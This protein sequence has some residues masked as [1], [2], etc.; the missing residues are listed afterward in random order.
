MNLK[1]HQSFQLCKDELN[2]VCLSCRLGMQCF[3]FALKLILGEQLHELTT[4]EVA[5]MLKNE[6]IT[7]EAILTDS[8]LPIVV[9]CY[10]CCI[11][12]LP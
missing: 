10:I 8:Y 9:L 2:T 11:A 12:P 5:N 4:T 7:A 1:E 3:N 6:T